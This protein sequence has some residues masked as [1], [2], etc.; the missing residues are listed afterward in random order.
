MVMEDSESDGRLADPTGA[1]ESDGRE[2]FG[3]SD[4]LLN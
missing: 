1:N 4:D 2:V 3:Q